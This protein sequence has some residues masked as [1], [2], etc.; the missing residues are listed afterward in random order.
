MQT[1]VAW[2]HPSKL[3]QPRLRGVCLP[4]LALALACWPLACLAEGDGPDFFRV[5]G[6]RHGTNLSVRAEPEAQAPKLGELPYN[7]EGI[8][9]L[10]CRGGLSFAEWEKANARER[11]AAELQRWCRVEWRN[12]TGWAMAKFLSEG[13]PPRNAA[14]AGPRLFDRRWLLVSSPA[15]DAVGDAWIEFLAGGEL[16]GKA[17]CNSFRGRAEISGNGIRAAPLQSTR[18][19][20]AAPAERQEAVILGMLSRPLTYQIRDNRLNLRAADGERELR[21]ALTGQ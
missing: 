8:R 1:N 20:C 5:V 16:V 9:N 14:I 7:A 21:Y 6:L 19:A 12:V 3:G 4:F 15:G 11:K 18:L 10:G 2:P 13:S 17:G